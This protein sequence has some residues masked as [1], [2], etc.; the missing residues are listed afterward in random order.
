[1]SA[2]FAQIALSDSSCLSTSPIP[3]IMPDR[4]MS[5]RPQLGRLWKTTP[6][7]S[8]LRQ[9]EWA[10]TTCTA[11]DL[12]LA[13]ACSACS[14]SVS[15]T[16]CR[17]VCVLPKAPPLDAG[18][19]TQT[20]PFGASLLPLHLGTQFGSC[21]CCCPLGRTESLSA[22]F[23]CLCSQDWDRLQ[24]ISTLVSFFLQEQLKC[25]G[26]HPRSKASRQAFSEV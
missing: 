15:K 6:N 14:D 10:C 13:S 4:N 19:G 24:S 26:K 3:L 16:L 20:L 7:G 12:R 2:Y 8:G 11:S 22:V 1:M 18:K 17:S 21:F 23:R 25:M 5:C 9:K